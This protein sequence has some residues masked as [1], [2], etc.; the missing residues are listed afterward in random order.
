[1]PHTVLHNVRGSE[2]EIENIFSSLSQ[3]GSQG[4]IFLNLGKLQ[5]CYLTL[6]G[7][8]HRS[9]ERMLIT[10]MR[11]LLST[12]FGPGGG[13]ALLVGGCGE[14]LT[15]GNERGFTSLLTLFA[16]CSDKG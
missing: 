4:K 9:S 6:V 14:T 2:V 11:D 8:K 3:P 10:W 5:P 13:E 12:M 7:E 1:M 15:L 16:N